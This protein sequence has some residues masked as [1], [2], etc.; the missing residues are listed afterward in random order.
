M[1][2]ANLEQGPG[3]GIASFHILA[4]IKSFIVGL[5]YAEIRYDPG[6]Y[7]RLGSQSEDKGH[8]LKPDSSKML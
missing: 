5:I 3:G 6:N 2:N 4:P 7:K 1:I 8:P